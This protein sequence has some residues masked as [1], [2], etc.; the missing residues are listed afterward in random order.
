[1]IAE[2]LGTTV[3]T[4]PIPIGLAAAGAAAGER[5]LGRPFISRE[6]IERLRED[7]VF[8]RSEAAKGLGYAPRP[9][10]DGLRAEIQS[11][12]LTSPRRY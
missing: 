11:M 10:A 4:M 1:M 5:L 8:D 3:I 6:Q 12:G 7:K 2:I 9:F